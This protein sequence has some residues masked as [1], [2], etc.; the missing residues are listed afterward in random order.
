[1]VKRFMVGSYGDQWENVASR[2]LSP[3]VVR[4]VVFL[5][6]ILWPI[7]IGMGY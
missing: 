3:Y 2:K 7:E 1:M 4:P 6:E 5:H